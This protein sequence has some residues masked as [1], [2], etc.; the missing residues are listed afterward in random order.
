MVIGMD[1]SW[2]RRQLLPGLTAKRWAAIGLMSF[3]AAAAGAIGAIVCAFTIVLRTQSWDPITISF[4][5]IILVGAA[6]GWVCVILSDRKERAEI[7]AGY[8]TTA[9][10][11]N[12]VAR[13]HS[14]T[15][16]VMRDAG[17]PNL[18]RPEWEAA[19]SRVRAFEA[20]RQRKK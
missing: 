12:E 5:S 4:V 2:D 6:F 18:S 17:R 3:A 14:P 15:G 19:M 7:K 11:N 20:T 1:K 10:G 9:Q 16:V 13:V 8:T